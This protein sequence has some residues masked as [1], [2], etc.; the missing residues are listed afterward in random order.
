[1]L[2]KILLG[3]GI[4]SSVLYVATD[5]IASR[6]YP[7]YS[8]ISQSTSELSA[9]GAP[10]RPFVLP[11]ELAS[12]MLLVAFGVG[13]WG[14]VGP[15]LTLRWMAGLL[16]GSAVMGLVATAFFPM[17]RSE[18]VSKR[19]NTMGVIIGALM[20]ICFVLAMGFGAAG[21]RNWFRYYSI[22]TLGTF[23]V[24]SIL[25]LLRP[26]PLPAGYRGSLVGLQERTMFYGYLLWVTVLAIGLL[27]AQKSE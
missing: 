21:F 24:L 23:V 4:V 27:R 15:K 17:H 12:N 6:R 13:V 8:F 16:I 22:G 2:R 3:C 25:G 10:T 20:V 19:P 26:L 14:V 9:I 1:M 18:A 11:L 7:G 5:V